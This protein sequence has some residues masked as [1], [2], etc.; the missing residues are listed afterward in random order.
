MEAV[1]KKG[2]RVPYCDWKVVYRTD[3]GTELIGFGTG[4]SISEESYTS[5]SC[6]LYEGRV[7]FVTRIRPSDLACPAISIS[8][9]PIGVPFLSSS[10]LTLPYSSAA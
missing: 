4:N 2:R 9:G 1:D 10:A 3:E 8:I 7:L 6:T 5:D